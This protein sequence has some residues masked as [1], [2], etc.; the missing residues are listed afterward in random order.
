MLNYDKFHLIFFSTF[1]N[2]FLVDDGYFDMERR[3]EMDMK[4]SSLC[5]AL[6]NLN[7]SRSYLVHMSYYL[8]LIPVSLILT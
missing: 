7:L 5:E 6:P 3:I 1:M 8:C 4:N 2:F